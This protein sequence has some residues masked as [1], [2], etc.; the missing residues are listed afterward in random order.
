MRLNLFK[1]ILLYFSSVFCKY[2]ISNYWKE[3]FY[4]VNFLFFLEKTEKFIIYKNRKIDRD[5][6][7]NGE[8]SISKVIFAIC[9]R[10]LL[11]FGEMDI[12]GGMDIE[13]VIGLESLNFLHSKSKN[14]N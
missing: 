8:K 1:H 11:W 9:E 14:I 10:R 4:P 12:E 7:L 5:F 3:G 2:P 6:L 13:R